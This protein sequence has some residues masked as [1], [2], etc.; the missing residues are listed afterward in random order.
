MEAEIIP[1]CEDQGMAVVPWEA[2]GGGKLLSTEQRR[3]QE[4]NPEARVDS[5]TKSDIKLCNALERLAEEKNTTLQAIVG[6][7]SVF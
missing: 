5:T 2:L 1:M 4:E 7:V 6:E 3:K